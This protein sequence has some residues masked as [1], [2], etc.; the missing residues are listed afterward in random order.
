VTDIAFARRGTASAV[1]VWEEAAAIIAAV[2][3][4]HDG[5]RGTM[6]YVGVD[7]SHRGK[8]LGREVMQTAETWLSDRGVWKVNLLVRND[9]AKA[10]GFYER[11]GY[12]KSDVISLAKQIKRLR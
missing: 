5:H 7:P 12:A 4:G 3:V 11:A 6:Y 2:M 10:I 9:N 8:G 1:L